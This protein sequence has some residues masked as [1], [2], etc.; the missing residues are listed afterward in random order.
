MSTKGLGRRTTAQLLKGKRYR[1]PTYYMRGAD[2]PEAVEHD[3]A[4]FQLFQISKRLE[5]TLHELREETIPDIGAIKAAQEAFN[6]ALNAV[7]FR[8]L[9][10]VPEDRPS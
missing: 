2:I 3:K 8:W 9:Q 1:V 7:R 4:F 10:L 5:K 6:E